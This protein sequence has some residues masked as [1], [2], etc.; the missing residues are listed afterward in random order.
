MLFVGRLRWTLSPK[1][2]YGA[3]L[4]DRGHSTTELIAATI[5]LFN[6]EYHSLMLNIKESKYLMLKIVLLWLHKNHKM[7]FAVDRLMDINIFNSSETLYDWMTNTSNNITYFTTNGL[8]NPV[9]DLSTG[10]TKRFRY[11]SVFYLLLDVDECPTFKNKKTVC[12]L[13]KFTAGFVFVFNRI[14]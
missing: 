3:S 13:K 4:S 5:N 14:S 6:V 8:L 2:R 12:A 11:V 7:F 10:Q 1:E 9:M